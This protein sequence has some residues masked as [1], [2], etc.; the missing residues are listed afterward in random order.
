MTRETCLAADVRARPSQSRSA[1]SRIAGGVRRSTLL[2]VERVGRDDALVQQPDQELGGGV[3]RDEVDADEQALAAHLGDQVRAVRRDGVDGEVADLRAKFACALDQAFGLDGADGRG[4]RGGRE[5]A[6]GER[7][8]VQQRVGVERREQLRGRHHA[9]DGHHAAA[10]DLARQQHVRR[11]AGEVSAPPGA[12]AAHAGLDL[13]EDHHGAGLGARLPDL[14][15]V[16]VGRQPDAALGLDGLEQHRRL[17]RQRGPQRGGI[18]ERYEVD[19]RQQRAE[20]VAV[21]RPPGHRQRAKRLAVE[22]AVHRDHVTLAGQ[23]GQLQP[24]LGRLGSRVRQEDVVQAGRRDA[25]QV[26]GRL[27]QLRVEE[28]PGGQGVTPQLLAHRRDDDRVAVA[29]QEDPE[30]RR[31]RGRC[32]R[33]CPAPSTRRRPPRRAPRRAAPGWRATCSRAW[34]S[35]RAPDPGRSAR[36]RQAAF[37]VSAWP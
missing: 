11:D 18:A 9:A 31:S 37:S 35:D 25:G 8:G 23:P 2:R 33:R 30:A 7:R 21:L 10:E 6:A 12:E 28:Q 16:A 14:P 26:R 4:D 29:E 13:V 20:R 34:C 24:E 27:S 32:A 5:R 15:Q 19:H 22:S 3:G 1:A 36:S 17:G